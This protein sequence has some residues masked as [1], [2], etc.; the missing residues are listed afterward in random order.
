MCWDSAKLT[1]PRWRWR[2]WPWMASYLLSMESRKISPWEFK[3]RLS[4][5]VRRWTEQ[6]PF[7][8]FQ[9][10]SFQ[11]KLFQNKKTKYFRNIEEKKAKIF[12]KCKCKSNCKHQLNCKS[13]PCEYFQRTRSV[14]G[15]QRSC[16]IFTVSLE[17]SV[18]WTRP[19][20]RVWRT[21]QFAYQ[22]KWNIFTHYVEI[23]S[24]PEL[25]PVC[26]TT[27][28]TYGNWCEA[29]ISGAEVQCEV[30]IIVS[31]DIL[32]LVES[33]YIAWLSL[34]EFL[35]CWALI[36]RAPTLL[37]S[38]WS[39]SYIAGLPLVELLHCWALIGR[40]LHNDEIFSVCWWRKLS[41]ALKNQ[42][43]QAMN[44]QRAIGT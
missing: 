43:G 20:D 7:L 36:S 8:S 34:V 19:R 40:E 28:V 27:G 9:A 26:S 23:F 6:L 11:A 29:N 3:S 30:S 22:V 44:S 16:L 32:S 14:P 17:R 4:L 1:S 39:S 42:L 37:S 21:T 35:H 33:S 25:P 18:G 24:I 10:K 13:R 38:H 41:F 12:R 5:L 15:L 2:C 31:L